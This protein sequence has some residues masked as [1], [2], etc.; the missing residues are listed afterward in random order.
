MPSAEQPFKLTVADFRYAS[1]PSGQDANLRW[2]SS[3][4]SYWVGYYHDPTFGAQSRVGFD[5]SIA[6]GESTTLQPSLQAASRG[7]AGGSVNL[8][9]GD[10]WFALVGWGRTNLKPYF[11]LNF[12][13]ND[14][15]TLGAGWHGPGGKTLSLT[16]VAD[17]RLHT[18]QRHWHAFARWPLTPSLRGTFDLLRKTGDG[19]TGPVRAWGWSA[20][21]DFPTWFLRL[22][23]DPKQNFSSQDVTRI[24]A[25]LRF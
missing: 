7:F 10:P 18:R 5:T 20:T 1:A 19:D 15:I 21:L 24:A 2:R 4:S 17:D 22:A 25:G 23:R 11:N 6:L 13:P 3:D 14:A 12:D 9:M 8:Q 16:L